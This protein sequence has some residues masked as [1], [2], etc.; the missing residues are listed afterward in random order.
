MAWTKPG[1]GR[2]RTLATEER[3][4]SEITRAIYRYLCRV[5]DDV[6]P[7]TREVAADYFKVV[8]HKEGV[9]WFAGRLGLEETDYERL[10]T[11]LAGMRV[12]D[13]QMQH[14]ARAVDSMEG[15]GVIRKVGDGWELCERAEAREAERQREVQEREQ[16]EQERER[17]ERERPDLDAAR[18]WLDDNWNFI[19]ER[20]EDILAYCGQRRATLH[21]AL[22][23]GRNIGYHDPKAIQRGLTL[24]GGPDDAVLLC[25]LNNY[26]VND[27]DVVLE[28]KAMLREAER[29]KAAAVQQ[30]KLEKSMEED[31]KRKEEAARK[32]EE[33]MR[34]HAAEERERK[35]AADANHLRELERELEVEIPKEMA[36][37]K[38]RFAKYAETIAKLEA[39]LAEREAAGDRTRAVKNKLAKA[40]E[41]EES[42]TTYR[43][44]DWAAEVEEVTAMVAKARA[45]MAGWE[46]ADAAQAAGKTVEEQ[47]A[48]GAAA[49]A[50][51]LQ[52]AGL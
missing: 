37:S 45:R 27:H 28:Q 13:K 33:R 24:L 19:T 47:R 17:Q 32:E 35:K 49:E 3:L 41:A 9:E 36:A 46:A 29:E 26:P 51:A 16:A 18:E 31:R 23:D 2:P 38:D 40:R 50:E 10:R 34:K 5:P 39:E 7:D 8:I 1:P 12:D 43:P 44:E 42:D 15:Q 6:Y 25:D 48:A 14:V 22:R 30:A 52:V 21:A 11:A 4:R 20:N